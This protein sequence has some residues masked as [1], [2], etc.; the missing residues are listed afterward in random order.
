MADGPAQDAMDL[1]GELSQCSTEADA[2]NLTRKIVELLGAQSFVYTTL[3]PPNF[4]AEDGDFR[5]FVGCNPDLCSIYHKRM[6]IMND[7]FFDYARTN[8]GPILG[9]KVKLQTPGQI[10]MMRVCAEHGFRSGL[11]VPTHTSMNSST[12]MGVLYIGLDVPVEI[13]EPILWRQRVRFGALGMELLLW[14]SSRMREKAMRKYS[15]IDEEVNL[16]QFSKKGMVATEIAALL[17]LKTAAVY[18]K[19]NAIKEKLDVDKIDQ[20]VKLAQS[21][22]LL[23]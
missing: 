13:G 1:I 2:N 8:N 23:G 15:L 14:W 3:L 11:V 21:V 10:E 4:Y 6:W 18:R 19:L 22:G 9:S 17:D 20:A 5:F 16:L 7:P 12:R